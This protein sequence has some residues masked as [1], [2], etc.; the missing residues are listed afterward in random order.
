M[1]LRSLLSGVLAVAL[2]AML[3]GCGGRSGSTAVPSKVSLTW[4]D[5]FGYSSTADR[6]ITALLGKYQAAYPDIEVKRT[7][8]KF[9]D[10]RAALDKAA[11]AGTFPDVVAIDNADVPMFAERDALADL[12]SRMQAWQGRIMFLD[13]V[14]RSAQVGDKAYGIPFRSNTTGRIQAINATPAGSVG[15]ESISSRA[16]AG[17]FHSSR[18]RGRL[19]SSAATNSR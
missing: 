8:I 1:R 9:A 19:L 10:F 6:A 12:T 14:Q 7:T 2:T 17:V 15:L 18:L 13:A 16:S 3:G 11:A 4:W 5:Y